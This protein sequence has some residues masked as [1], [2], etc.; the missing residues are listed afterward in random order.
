MSDELDIEDPTT[1]TVNAAEATGLRAPVPW[2]TIWGAI[3]AVL[4]TF[5]LLLLVRELARVI[6]WSVMAA[7]LAAVLTPAVDL[8]HHRYKV[9]RGIA[10]TVV[11]VVG[12]LMLAGLLTAFIVPLVRQ[13]ANF[14]DDL[15]G[16]VED[17]QA[18]RG[19]IGRI[20]E[21]YDLQEW[22]EENQDRLEE[23]V[24]QIGSRSLGV[25]QSIFAGVI[26][27]VTTFVLTVF[28]VAS[29]PRLTRGATMLI[30]EQHRQRARVV[31]GRSARAVSGY[32]FGNVV[33]SIVAGLSTWL[34]LVML[35]VPYAGVLALWVA[36]ADLIPMVGATLGAIPTIA[37]SFLH[38]TRAG[39]VAL[40]FYI[41]YQ[42]FENHVLQPVIM[43]RSVSVSPLAVFVAA[44]CGIE[45]AG[46]VGALLAVPAAGIIQVVVSDFYDWR[47]GELKMPATAG[48]PKAQ[49]VE[50]RR[51]RAMF[52]SRWSGAARRAEAERAAAA[53][54][55]SRPE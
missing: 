2:R 49:E 12:L 21:R 46:F 20:I 25:L 39:I 34:V 28:I 50:R 9:R 1:T 7:F 41:A 32:V 31:G 35:G 11:L 5:V 16:Y 22:L 36:F 54:D 24:S 40:I 18:G 6:L 3:G 27:L 53:V 45:L 43:S 13:G 48:G 29:G 47:R 30:P 19:P 15:P 23:F 51:M 8:L 26:A 42:Q 37:F 44:L 17:A 52:V 14:A 33:I 4:L 10:I 55:A 38:S